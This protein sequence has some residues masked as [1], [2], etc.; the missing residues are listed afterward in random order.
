ML[1]RT[2]VDRRAAGRILQFE[3]GTREKAG[4]QSSADTA[5][6]GKK[7]GKEKSETERFEA[8]GLCADRPAFLSGGDAMWEMQT[9]AP[10][11]HPPRDDGTPAPDGLSCLVDF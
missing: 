8:I 4:G 2:S 10:P 11:P 1:A 7:K 5:L 9:R 6:R 3:L